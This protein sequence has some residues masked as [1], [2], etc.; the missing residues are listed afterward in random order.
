M[1]DSRVLG[2]SFGID[3]IFAALWAPARTLAAIHVGGLPRAVRD[4]THGSRPF[5]LVGHGLKPSGWI[6]VE[7]RQTGGCTAKVH[8]GR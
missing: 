5:R 6:E 3:I 4:F 2:Q 7:A 1:I 8:K